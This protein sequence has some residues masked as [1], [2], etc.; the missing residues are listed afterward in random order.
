MSLAIITI[1]TSITS[2]VL[3]SQL[4]KGHSMIQTRRLKNV[5]FSKKKKK[6]NEDF[7]ME[8]RSVI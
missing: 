8:R 4:E 5:I 1:Y 7:A 2:F 6:N 3:I